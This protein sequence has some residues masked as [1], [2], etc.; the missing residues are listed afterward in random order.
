MRSLAPRAGS[1][2]YTRM[3]LRA[4]T[5]IVVGVA[6]PLSACGGH[7]DSQPGREQSRLEVME[8]R[9]D[10]LDQ[11]L[12]TT[13]K[14]LAAGARL[15]ENMRALEQRL[16][17]V[18]AKA[19]QAL[20]AA[21]RPPAPAT[22]ARTGAAGAAAQP[23]PPDPLERRAQLGALMTEYRR[24]L[25]DMAKQQDSQ[26][27]VADRLA[28]RRSLREW[29]IAHRRAILAGRPLPDWHPETP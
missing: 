20:D 7:D 3:A 26:T 17:A 5:S 28:A 18:D 9:L 14:D 13:E 1:R 21:K 11:R 12:A 19:T 16:G 29:Y 24:R 27:S 4:V 15:S 8:R 10:Q 25:S 2:H 6:I 22:P 23:A